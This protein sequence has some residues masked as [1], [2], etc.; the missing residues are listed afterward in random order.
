MNEEWFEQARQMGLNTRLVGCAMAQLDQAVADGEIPGGVAAIGRKGQLLEYAAGDAGLTGAAKFRVRTDTRYDCASLTKIV[1]TL[2]LVLQLL[3]EGRLRLDDAVGRFI[4]AFD[5]EGGTKSSVTI[6]HLLTHTSGLAPFVDLHTHGWTR[7]QMLSFVAGLDLEYE[8]GT[9][10]VYSDLGFILLGRLIS[11]LL[12]MPLEEAAAKR[13]FEPL[14]MLDSGYRPLP[15]DRPRIAPT[16]HYAY[17][18][19]PRW[20]IVHDEN[21]GAMGGVSGHAGL[22][23]TARDLIRYAAMWLN[24]G[25][26]E[27]KRLLSRSAVRLAARNQTASAAG[28]TRGLGWVLKG[29]KWDASGDLL[30]ERSYGHTGFT[31]TSLYIDPEA[32]LTVALL[33]NRVH[34]GRDKSVARLRACFHNA[35]AASLEDLT[36]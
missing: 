6:R 8:P 18:P 28:G 17:E 25:E 12:G 13:I 34:L 26:W 31:G 14:G 11:D 16:E 5:G 20:G 19:E 24:E 15:E 29:D 7:E 1:V 10:V 9:Q 33:T 2:P 27:G 3:D 30:S 22:F 23:A 21:A 4:P 35:V 32:G 36:I